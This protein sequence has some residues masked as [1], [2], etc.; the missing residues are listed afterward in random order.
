MEAEEELQQAFQWYSVGGFES[1]EL[2]LCL[3]AP[4]ARMKCSFLPKNHRKCPLNESVPGKHKEG[5]YLSQFETPIGCHGN[6]FCHIFP[7]SVPSSFP[8]CGRQQGCHMAAVIWRGFV[9]FPPLFSFWPVLSVMKTFCFI[10]TSTPPLLLAESSRTWCH[11]PSDLISWTPPSREGLKSEIGPKKKEINKKN[12]LPSEYQHK[13]R[14]FQ[15]PKDL[16]SPWQQSPSNHYSS[17]LSSNPFVS[18]SD[19]LPP[20]NPSASLPVFYSSQRVSSAPPLQIAPASEPE[21]CSRLTGSR[22]WLLHLGSKCVTR[23]IYIFLQ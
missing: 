6:K 14:T 12:P 20:F 23:Y 17:K 13:C 4:F 19:S 11:P 7:P 22:D 8:S 18:P 16:L 3:R 1:P 15:M 10:P 5:G 2:S 9:F 21:D